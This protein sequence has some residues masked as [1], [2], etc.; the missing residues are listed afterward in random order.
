MKEILTYALQ[1]VAC[2]AL[3]VVFYRVVLQRR[4]SFRTARRY[5]L[6]SPVIAA[7]I[8]ALD[9]PVWHVAPIEI[10]LD[11]PVSASTAI[12]VTAP[13]AVPPVDRVAIVLWALWGAGIAMLVLIMVHQMVKIASIRRRAK[14]HNA[15]GF[16]IALSG[17]VGPPFSFLRTVFISHGTPGDEMRQIVM[18]EASHIRHRHSTEKL[19]MEVVKSLQW[20]NPFAWWAARLLAEVHEF[21]ADRDVLDGGFTVEEYLPLILR[22]TFGYIPELSAGLGDSLTKKRFLM[23]KNKM[24]PTKRGWLR[25]AGVLPLAA[26]AMLLFSF[27]SRPPAIIFTGGTASVETSVE[28]ALEASVQAP[29]SE[30]MPVE[31]VATAPARVPAPAPES[32]QQPDIPIHNAEVMPTFDGGGLSHFRDW[33]QRQLVYPREALERGISGT[34]T[35]KYV[36]ERDGSVSNIETLRSPG[37]LLSAEAERVIGMSPKWTPGMQAGKPVRVYYILPVMFRLTEDGGSATTPAT[38]PASSN[39]IEIANGVTVVGYGA[40]RHDANSGSNYPPANAVVYLNGTLGAGQPLI[41][42][43]NTEIRSMSSVD[44]NTIE[45]INVLKDASA[46]NL[47]GD[48]AKNGVVVIT[49]KRNNTP[50]AGSVELSAPGDTPMGVIYDV[51]QKLREAGVTKV[52]YTLSNGEIMTTEIE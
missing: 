26:G 52:T 32:P 50:G 49:T 44:P 39:R 48:R 31:R 15:D 38:T 17:E 34:V 5:L 37:N 28:V 3:F 1:T 8:P 11:L 21:E 36:I 14:L 40:Q 27:T 2:S 20:F 12:P 51:K 19:A 4:T 35:V 41:I 24:K 23:M 33:V 46:M 45:S 9:I 30:T 43:D 7:I 13:V 25:V 29:V 16:C 42:L 18:H 47:Y 22:Q 6:A 10:P